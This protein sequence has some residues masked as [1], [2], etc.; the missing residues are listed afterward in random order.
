MNRDG[1]RV[2]S[3]GSKWLRSNDDFSLLPPARRPKILLG[4]QPPGDP[5]HSL[6]QDWT[7]HL[8]RYLLAAT[9]HRVPRE[10]RHGD[11][12]LVPQC[13]G[14]RQR[15]PGHAQHSPG[16]DAVRGQSDVGRVQQ[17]QRLER[18]LWCDSVDCPDGPPG[19]CQRNEAVRALSKRDDYGSMANAIPSA[20][21]C[22]AVCS[23]Q[24]WTHDC[25]R[26]PFSFIVF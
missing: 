13:Q 5:R 24:V 3:S 2:P 15:L 18:A 26:P 12:P 16:T 6:S 7:G 23:P 11:D 25:G 19:F 20:T 1:Q 21:P 22:P 17:H 4:R 14:Q 10:G 9:Q 8:L